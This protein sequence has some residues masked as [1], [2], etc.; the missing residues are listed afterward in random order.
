MSLHRLVIVAEKSDAERDR[1]F[2][3]MKRLLKK[4]PM[5]VDPSGPESAPIYV[6]AASSLGEDAT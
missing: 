1:E 6:P 5:P 4:G 2:E 3:R